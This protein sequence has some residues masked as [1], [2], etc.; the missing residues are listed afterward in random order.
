MAK[1]DIG[2]ILA[3]GSTKQ[4]LL[5]LIEDNARA[6]YSR[7]RL[8]TDNEINQL[9]ETFK[10]PN[11]IKLYNS[12]LKTD[13]AVAT[14]IMNLQ[15]LKFEVLMH[16]S[17]L[18]GY[19]LVWETI[20]EAEILSNHI[21]HKI[22]DQKERIKIGSQ[23][24]KLSNFLFS[25]IQ[26]DKEGY[27][28]IKIDFEEKDYDTMGPEDKPVKTKKFTLWHIMNNVRDEAIEAATKFLSWRAAML[29]YMEEE[30]FNI[31]TYKELI[32]SMTEDIYQPII[33]WTKYQTDAEQFIP[34]IPHTRADKLK[35]KYSITPNMKKLE[36]DNDIYNYF[37]KEHLSNGQ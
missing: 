14:A 11:E 24:G 33:G 31:K 18:R 1:K 13:R 10:K 37:K 23:A 27:L 15:G 25:D 17:N 26:I 9:S 3:T 16:Y 5:L 29:D 21:L 32:Y 19:I 8:L 4:R 36:V 7:E 30:G 2:K 12:W 35:A 20:Q 28:D 6:R 34:D 22:K